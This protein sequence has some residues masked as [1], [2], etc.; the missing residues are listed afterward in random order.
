MNMITNKPK[1]YLWFIIVTLIY[2]LVM[3]I[4]ATFLEKLSDWAYTI[5]GLLELTIIIWGIYLIIDWFK[6]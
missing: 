5:I 3:I 6:K 4:T 1:K 2:Q